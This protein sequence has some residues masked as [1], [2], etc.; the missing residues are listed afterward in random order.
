MKN[1]KRFIVSFILNILVFLLV[2]AGTIIMMVDKGDDLVA[3]DITV[4]KYF[5]FQSNVFMAL[6]AAVFGYYQF[7][8]IRGKFDKIPQILGIFNLIGTNAVTLTFAVVIAFLV[9]QY[10]FISMYKSANLFFHLLVPVAAMVNYIFFAESEQYRLAFTPLAVVPC[11]L[12]GIVYFSVVVALEAYGDP[13][14]DF[15]FFGKNG[16]VIGAISFLIVLIVA[17]GLAL[18]LYFTNRL[19]FKKSK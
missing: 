10:G 13:K 8:V 14:I 9:P 3:R 19:S 17:Y 16:P 18:A 2:V 12:Y 6:V 15:Y 4:F 11:F 1:N 7:L 5:T